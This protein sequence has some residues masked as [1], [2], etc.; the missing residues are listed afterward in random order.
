VLH[1]R[2]TKSSVSIN[3]VEVGWLRHAEGNFTVHAL[4]LPNLTK[5]NQN[6]R[7][8]ICMEGGGGTSHPEC[9]IHNMGPP[10]PPCS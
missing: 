1:L 6:E 5:P 7:I 9:L 8:I 3:E 4:N 2:D 10:C